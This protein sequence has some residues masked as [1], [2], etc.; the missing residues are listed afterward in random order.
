MD[1]RAELGYAA[2]NTLANVKRKHQRLV[3]KYHPDKAQVQARR[4]GAV[5]ANAEKFKRVMRAW[6]NAQMHYSGRGP[7]PRA[8]APRPSAPRPAPES[9]KER[10]AREARERKQAEEAFRR[11]LWQLDWVVGEIAELLRGELSQVAHR[12]RQLTQG[13]AWQ[14]AEMEDGFG[15]RLS[16]TFPGGVWKV[17][18]HITDATLN[19]Q[20]LD[21]WCTLS[22]PPFYG[23]LARFYKSR[24][25]IAWKANVDLDKL[26]PGLR[27]ALAAAFKKHAT[28]LATKRSALAK[29]ARRFVRFGAVGNI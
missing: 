25:G 24:R 2:G 26:D 20:H 11:Q 5:T 14:L 27:P 3:M 13:G 12:A 29:A 4:D 8:A 10:Q 9:Y 22:V 15:F 17:S 21:L 18:G 23:Y 19:M 1:W 28:P 16:K 6:E 7:A